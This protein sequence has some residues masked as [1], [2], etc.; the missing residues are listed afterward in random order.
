MAERGLC[1]NERTAIS[2][3]V[4]E[5]MKFSDENFESLK[6]IVAN[7]EPIFRKTAGA[8]PQVGYNSD[9]EVT[10]TGAVAADAYAQLS[11][12]FGTKKSVF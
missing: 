7:H 10:V 12:M 8:I 1:R 2:D 3:Q 6:R 9:S 4:E 11:S 5:I